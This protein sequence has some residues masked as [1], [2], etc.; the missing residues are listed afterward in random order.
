[1]PGWFAGAESVRH[2]DMVVQEHRRTRM[3]P[4]E[5]KLYGAVSWARMEG[6]HLIIGHLLGMR[7]V[8]WA[9]SLTPS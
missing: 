2:S 8:M 7:N 5:M 6:K 1:M 4:T 3:L 9:L